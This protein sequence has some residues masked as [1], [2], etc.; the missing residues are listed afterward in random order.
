MEKTIP[1]TGMFV[2]WLEP[3]EAG[4]LAEVVT[5]FITRYG[6]ENLRV[7]SITNS[8]RE[9]VNRYAVTLTKDKKEILGEW[10]ETESGPKPDNFRSQKIWFNW[11][12]LKVV[13]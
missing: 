10:N 1:R 8:T 9:S 2:T 3:E 7:H 4:E 11:N 13:E 5:Y 6:K 12:L